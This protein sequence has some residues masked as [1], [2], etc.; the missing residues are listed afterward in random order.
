MRIKVLTA[1]ILS[2]L[3]NSAHAEVKLWV[4]CSTTNG[5]LTGS[6]HNI[7]ARDEISVQ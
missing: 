4:S 5:D 1:L 3:A 2:T 7:T 6:D